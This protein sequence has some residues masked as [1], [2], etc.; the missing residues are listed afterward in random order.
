MSFW[1]AQDKL[2]I[3]GD[4]LFRRGV[5]RMDLRG[6]DYKAIERSIRQRLY[7]LDEEAIVATGHGPDTLLAE[8]MCEHPFI[9]A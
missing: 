3:A 2:L 8:K 6:G 4:T 1:F 9:R 5:G 7:S